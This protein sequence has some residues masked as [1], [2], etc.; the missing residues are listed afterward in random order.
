ME[1]RTVLSVVNL[2]MLLVGLGYWV[3]ALGERKPEAPQPFSVRVL[4]PR[5]WLPWM[6]KEWYTPKGYRYQTVGNLLVLGAILIRLLFS[7]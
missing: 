4:H 2:A 1:W 6:Q 3:A 5:Y 7:P